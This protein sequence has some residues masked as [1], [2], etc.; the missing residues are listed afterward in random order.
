VISPLARREWGELAFRFETDG[1]R[2]LIAQAEVAATT[3]G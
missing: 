1:Y 2:F 3:Q